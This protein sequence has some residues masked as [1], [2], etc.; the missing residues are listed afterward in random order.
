MG[1]A[2]KLGILDIDRAA[3]L[4]GTRFAVYKGIGAKLERALASFMLDI[5]TKENEYTEILPTF[6]VNSQSLFG[7]GNLPKFESELYKLNE[8]DYWLIPTA[9]V[10][11]TCLYRDEILPPSSLP[12]KL[13]AWTPCFR[14]EAGSHGRDVRGILRQ[15]HF[16]KVE[17]VKLVRPEHSYAELEGLVK[18]AEKILQRLEIPYR[19]VL[20]CSGDTGF[21]SAKTYDIEAYLPGQKA[22]REISSCSNC[23]AFQARRANMRFRSHPAAKPE[24][25]HTLNGSGLAIGRTWLAILENYQQRDGAV[26]IPDALSPY[27]DGA[28]I[29]SPS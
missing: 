23:D 4:T 24:F 7:T 20:L 18:D 29:L 15:H 2:N 25:V 13:T 6:V 21:A 28:R 1:D 22:Y 9:E 19:V 3:K 5:H 14:R 17:L 10:P 26:I 27:L 16:Q 11:L 12:I 8:T